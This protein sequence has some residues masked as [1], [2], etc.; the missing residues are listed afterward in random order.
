MASAI[1]TVNRGRSASTS[2]ASTVVT[3]YWPRAPPQCD[4]RVSTGWIA[5]GTRKAL[6]RLGPKR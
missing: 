4:F 6:A 1:G 2:V 3:P 5:G